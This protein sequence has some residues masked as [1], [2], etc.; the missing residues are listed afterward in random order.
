MEKM[1]SFDTDG[2]G[3]QY[4]SCPNCGMHTSSKTITYTEDG[5]VILGVDKTT[6]TIFA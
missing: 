5:D 3:V 6:K 2:K 4:W 1:F